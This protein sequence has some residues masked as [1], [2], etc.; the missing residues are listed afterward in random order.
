M[1]HP[2]APIDRLEQAH[3]YRLQRLG[4][5]LRY[6]LMQV[7]QPHRITPEQFM[8]LFRLHERDGR[9]QKELVDPAFDDRAN[10][11]HLVNQLEKAALVRRVADDEDRR[12]RRL[13]LTERGLEQLDA[14]LDRV[15]AVRAALF[16]DFSEAE[17]GQL[18]GFVERLEAHLE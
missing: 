11:T 16:Q 4:R 14:L 17:L 3:A 18:M 1:A 7:L 2:L 6:H 10:I 15:L 12:Q 13:F 9:L 8:I 5:L